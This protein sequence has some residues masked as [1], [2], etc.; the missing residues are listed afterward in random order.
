MHIRVGV[1][2][3]PQHC[4]YDDLARAAQTI[5]R[6]GF[7]TLWT[8]DHFYPLYG[9]PGAPMGEGLPPDAGEPPHRGDHFEGWT[10]LTAF[11]C[12]TRRVEI[13]MLVSCNS[14]RNPHLLADMVR[15]NDHVSKGR[16][17]LGLGSGWYDKDYQEYDYPFG[18]AV[19]RLRDLEANLPI[20]Q[21]RLA[22]LT[23]PP[24]RTPMPLMIGGGGEKITLRLVAEYAT[25]WNY[26]ADPEG[27]RHKMAVLDQW[28]AKKGRD[29][30]EVERSILLSG[31]D[32]L[33]QLDTYLEMGVTHFILGL[34]LPFDLRV[35]E[36][37]LAWRDAR[38]A[39]R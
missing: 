5:D 13:G 10:L 21:R 19:S 18:T 30:K 3:H 36:R 23:P 8:W 20:I 31:P 11:A 2:L 28:C 33:A 27:M 22:A 12:L 29:P 15:T 17:I 25:M 1:Q 38:Q 14:Y 32:P 9:S 24:L 35:A 6:L 37:L 34:G 4:T 16:M 26:F 39:G 7:D